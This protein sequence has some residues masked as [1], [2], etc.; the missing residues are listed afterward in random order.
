MIWVTRV[1]FFD[2]I[3]EKFGLYLS[4]LGSD[5]VMYRAGL[6]GLQGFEISHCSAAKGEKPICHFRKDWWK[7][8]QPRTSLSVQLSNRKASPVTFWRTFNFHSGRAWARRCRWRWCGA[9]CP[10]SCTCRTRCSTPGSRSDFQT[11][12]RTTSTPSL[13]A[14]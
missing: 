14:S 11:S 8:S 13:E 7:I 12:S 6:K 5:W 4:C 10:G 2:S 9:T 3:P 1:I